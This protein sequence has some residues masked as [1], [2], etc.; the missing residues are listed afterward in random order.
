[1][2]ALSTLSSPSSETA[3]L[4]G[5]CF[6]CLEAVFAELE[7]VRSVR[8]GY[9]GGTCPDPHY[10]AVCTGRSGHAEVV[11]IVFD[12]TL[13]PFRDLLQ[14]FF[15]IHDPTTPDRQGNDIGSQYR[16]VVFCQSEDQRL[17]VRE[18]IDAL[19]R[20][21]TWSAPVV[22]EI[23]AAAPFFPAEDE[24]HGYFE[25]NPAASYCQVVVAPKVAKL[26]RQFRERLKRKPLGNQ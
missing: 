2:N 16:S 19:A 10:E 3:L 22:T 20:D 13:L 15:A 17:Q 7:G 6:W 18:V 9:A 5:G 21:G 14:V 4:G 24:H 11:E 23:A 26:R 12:P 1:M 25:R 8:P